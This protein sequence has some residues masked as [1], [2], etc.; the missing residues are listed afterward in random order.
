MADYIFGRG[1]STSEL[2]TTVCPFEMAL[3]HVILGW[4]GTHDQVFL[5]PKTAD[6][7]GQFSEDAEI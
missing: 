5:L 3:A 6:P 4:L 1:N 2:M 7:Q